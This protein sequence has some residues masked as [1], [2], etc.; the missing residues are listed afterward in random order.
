MRL[1]SYH[2]VSIVCARN[3][4]VSHRHIYVTQ[5]IVF[6]MCANVRSIE[7]SWIISGTSVFLPVAVCMRL[8]FHS[9]CLYF[10][11]WCLLFL[12]QH[13]KCEAH[14]STQSEVK[15]HKA[16]T[17]ETTTTKIVYIL[18][19]NHNELSVIL[20]SFCRIFFCS[21]FFWIC[22]PS[23]PFCFTSF[24]FFRLLSCHSSSHFAARFFF[25]SRV[26]ITFK[27]TTKANEFNLYTS[28][29]GTKHPHTQLEW[30][31]S[32]VRSNEWVSKSECECTLHSASGPTWEANEEKKERQKLC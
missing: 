7:T 13:S 16:N 21:Y 5:T 30:L 28:W 8:F 9:F 19:R 10:H 31:E 2:S 1:S 22:S 26:A 15:W 4:F 6:R 29:L 18:I 27:H 25:Y 11:F 20:S 14:S 23:R 12:I 32:G 24:L 17:M 3:P